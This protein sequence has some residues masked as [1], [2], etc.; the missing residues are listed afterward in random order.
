MIIK[1]DAEKLFVKIPQPFAIKNTIIRNRHFFNLI[2]NILE[3]S[4]SI[5]ILYDKRLKSFHLR[6]R[7]ITIQHYT[8]S[9]S[10]LSDAKKKK[11]DYKKKYIKFSFGK[12]INRIHKIASRACKRVSKATRHKVNKQKINYISRY[13]QKR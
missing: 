11:K 13:M 7:A 3:K 10:Q 6:L 9:S 12:F 4:A 5:I 8:N 2:K 1:I